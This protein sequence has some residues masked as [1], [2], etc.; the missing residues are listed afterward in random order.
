VSFVAAKVA[1]VRGEEPAALADQAA[2]NTVRF[3]GW[4]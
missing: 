1:E 3:F 4:A 2:R